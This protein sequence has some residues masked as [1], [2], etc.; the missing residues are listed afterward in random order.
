MSDLISKQKAIDEIRAFQEQ[1]TLSSSSDWIAG[2]NEGFDHAVSV[3]ELMDTNSMNT[4]LEK[5]FA[6]TQYGFEVKFTNVSRVHP[7]SMIVHVRWHN[8]Y[9]QMIINSDIFG[10]EDPEGA[11]VDLLDHMYDEINYAMGKDIKNEQK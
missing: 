7:E 6:L 8:Y 2:M 10:Y 5:I 11:I 4:L 3:I 1:V 9:N